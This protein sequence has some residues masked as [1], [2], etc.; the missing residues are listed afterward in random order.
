[1]IGSLAQRSVRQRIAGLERLFSRSE[2]SA[3][4]RD[5]QALRLCLFA[6]DALMIAVAVGTANVVRVHLDDIALGQFTP[7]YHLFASALVF[8]LLLGLF[9]LRDLYEPDSILAGTRE[10]AQIANA[11]T[12]GVMMALAASYFVGNAQLVSRAWLILVWTLCIVCVGAGRFLARRVVRR[13]RREG[14]FRTRIAIVGASSLSVTIADQLRTATD[15]GLDVVGFL[16]EYI[17]VGQPLLDDIKV[18]GRPHDLLR[19]PPYRL[20]DE[21]I[22]V[23]QALPHERQEDISRLIAAQAKPILRMAVSSS[24]LLTHGVRVRERGNVPLVNVER[25]RLQGIEAL[26]KRAF[27]LIGATIALALLAPVTALIVVRNVGRRPLFQSHTIHG[28][29]GDI[30][31]RVFD[32]DVATGPLLRGVPALLAVLT[33]Q[34]SLVGP[35]PVLSES[36]RAAAQPVGLTAIKPGLTGPWRLSGPEATLAEQALDD[37]TYVRN[38]S[39]WEDVRIVLES[40]RRLKFGHLQTL[41]GRWQ[42]P[43]ARNSHHSPGA[44]ENQIA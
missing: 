31:L 35:R 26:W 21:Y 25:A 7:G 36:E 27:D 18:V 38:Y 11:S 33:G 17:P 10:Y 2:F 14:L 13:L 9:W 3:F 24:E 8:P 12:Y 23:P 39:I 41:L 4:G 43:G 42:A 32:Y 40:V 1:V 20:A 19:N 34:F 5:W 37:L 44:F 16:D 6:T 15:Q 28:A 30:Q 29:S 22:L